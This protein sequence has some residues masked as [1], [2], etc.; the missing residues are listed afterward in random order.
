M[1][2]EDNEIVLE[3][4]RFCQSVLDAAEEVT[5]SVKG[6]VRNALT[7]SNLSQFDECVDAG[8]A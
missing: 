6:K 8:N 4:T 3:V 1:A 5:E 7:T 2:I